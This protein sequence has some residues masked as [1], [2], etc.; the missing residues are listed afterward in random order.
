MLSEL[1]ITFHHTISDGLSGAYLIRDEVLPI[2]LIS[3]CT[4]HCN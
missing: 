4:I 2:G 1:I 3:P